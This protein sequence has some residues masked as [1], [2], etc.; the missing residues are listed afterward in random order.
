MNTSLFMRVNE[1][2]ARKKE[3]ESWDFKREWHHEKNSLL[4]DIICM[5]NLICEEDGII[6]IGVD[7]ENG[8]EI[9]DVSGDTNR[10]NTQQ[11]V[12]F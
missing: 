8:F 7:E 2:I 10:R 12:D 3:G 1:C 11:L 9:H 6:I 4:H 5:S